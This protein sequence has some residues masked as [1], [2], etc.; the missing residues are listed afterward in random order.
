V[1]WSGFARLARATWRRLP[2]LAGAEPVRAYAGV[3]SLTPDDHPILGPVAEAPG[4]F[5][6]CGFGGHGIMHSPA[7]GRLLAEWIVDGEPRSW[8]ARGLTL[9]RFRKGVH[10]AE[11]TAF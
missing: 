6:A 4:L 10:G 3:R 8:D 7:A 1:D 2:A 9:E 11:A 5:L